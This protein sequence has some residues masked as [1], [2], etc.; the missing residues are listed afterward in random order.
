[1]A[2]TANRHRNNID[3]YYR[4]RSGRLAMADTASRHK[5]NID[6]YY[7]HRIGCLTHGWHHKQA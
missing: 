6:L 1:M 7:I 3:H 5:N 2:G 4:N